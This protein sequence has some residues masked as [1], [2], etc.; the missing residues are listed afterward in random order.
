MSFDDGRIH[1]I[2]TKEQADAAWKNA[3]KEIKTWLEEEKK[4][5]KKVASYATLRAF[6]ES[7]LN[8][9][10]YPFCGSSQANIAFNN[11]AKRLS[12]IVNK[13]GIDIH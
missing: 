10:A 13:I 7:V 5:G 4:S 3:E 6:N 2:H 12:K 8:R 1:D 11:H 9:E